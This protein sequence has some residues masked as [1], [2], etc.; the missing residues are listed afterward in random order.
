MTQIGT[1]S[2]IDTPEARCPTVLA[3]NASALNMPA[4]ASETPCCAVSSDGS[5][6]E[7]EN[8]WHE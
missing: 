7:S 8:I 3:A 2:L 4:L 6:K 5:A 1:P